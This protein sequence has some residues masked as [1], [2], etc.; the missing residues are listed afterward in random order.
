MVPIKLGRLGLVQV[1]PKGDGYSDLLVSPRVAAAVHEYCRRARQVPQQLAHSTNLTIES[2]WRGD[3]RKADEFKAWIAREFPQEAFPYVQATRSERQ[4]AAIATKLAAAP[5]IG[6]RKCVPAAG[7]IRRDHC[8]MGSAEFDWNRPVISMAPDASF[9]CVGFIVGYSKVTGLA[10]VILAREN[11]EFTTLGGM[12][13]KR[14]GIVT[15]L[16][17]LLQ[18]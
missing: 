9:G 17:S 2:V 18:L 4:C 8:E 10:V 12:I 3:H 15:G 14:T 5:I 1:L 11:P 13:P 6:F 7:V 16:G